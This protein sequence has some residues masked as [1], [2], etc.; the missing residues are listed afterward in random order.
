MIAEFN[1]VFA[2]DVSE[3]GCTHLVEHTIKTGDHPP[4]RQQPYRTPVV[5][6]QKLNEL[7]ADIGAQ[8]I[9]QP[10]SSPCASPVVLVPKTGGNLRFCIDNRRLNAITQKDVYPLP[11]VDDILVT[12]GEAQYFTS[13]DL[14]SG[15]L[16]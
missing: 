11:R 4:I 6:Y 10:S 3:L 7:V 14:A 2:L 16:V 13:L 15:R 1:D 9:I 12:L 5:R 8:G